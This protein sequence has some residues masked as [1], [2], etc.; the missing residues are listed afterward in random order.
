MLKKGVKF[1][2]KAQFS[3][4]YLLMMGFALLLLIPT[5]YLFINESN[6]IKSDIALSQLNKIS[7]KL[8]EK[9]EEV[10]Y[11]GAPSRTTIT[12][13]F[14]Y[15]IKNISIQGKDILF[16]YEGYENSTLTVLQ[17]CQINVTGN[18]STKAGVHNIL[19]KSEGEY[20]SISE[21]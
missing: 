5:I 12:A 4:E 1:S 10:Y 13:N 17:T 2:R 14:P 16:I 6:N 18:I 19:I 11:Q 8:S 21:T 9:S 20:V 3:M 7:L 15:G